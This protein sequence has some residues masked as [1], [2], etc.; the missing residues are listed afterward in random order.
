MWLLRIHSSIF[1]FSERILQNDRI[2][3]SR[4][5][6]PQ[7]NAMKNRVF[8]SCTLAAHW[9]VYIALS[10]TIQSRGRSSTALR[11]LRNSRCPRVS[12]SR[13]SVERRHTRIVV[14]RRLCI[15]SLIKLLLN[16]RVRS[17]IFHSDQ[18]EPG[19]IFI[20]D[21]TLTY[22]KWSFEPDQSNRSSESATT[23]W[24]CTSFWTLSDDLRYSISC[25]CKGTVYLTHRCNSAARELHQF[26][27]LACTPQDSPCAGVRPRYTMSRSRAR[28]ERS[29]SFSLSLRLARSRSGR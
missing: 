28:S 3:T 19:K 29:L 21:L 24:L 10:M 20:N 26:F 16:R 12:L 7:W 27:V 22:K 15:T 2:S 14:T 5:F 1:L 13:E 25:A 23:L 4:M 17:F 8:P 11:A 18:V 9:P 6:A